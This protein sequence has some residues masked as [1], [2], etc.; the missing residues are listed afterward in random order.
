MMLIQNYI[1]ELERSQTMARNVT[2]C[3]RLRRKTLFMLGCILMVVGVAHRPW[4]LLLAFS[5]K[6]LTN[7]LV[8]V[9]VGLVAVIIIHEFAQL[10]LRG[11][12]EPW[13]IRR[14]SLIFLPIVLGCLNALLSVADH[15]ASKLFDIGPFLSSHAAMCMLIAVE[16]IWIALLE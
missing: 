2:N 11:R 10:V 7:T 14:G 8:L 6:G 13:Y 4:M 1:D 16:L 12:G 9:V 15:V 5:T 3:F